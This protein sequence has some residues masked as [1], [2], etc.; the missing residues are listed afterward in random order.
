MSFQG[1]ALLHLTLVK[2]SLAMD[3]AEGL[4]KTVQEKG[5]AE[6]REVGGPR[7]LLTE[8]SVRKSAINLNFD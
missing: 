8:P 5:E 6:N 3:D 7:W 2:K 4:E 1:L